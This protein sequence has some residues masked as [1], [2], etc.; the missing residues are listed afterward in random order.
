MVAFPAF[1]HDFLNKI[2]NDLE[3]VICNH[4]VS[5]LDLA[6]QGLSALFDETAEALVGAIADRLAGIKVEDE[7]PLALDCLADGV[8]IV[9]SGVDGYGRSCEIHHG[10]F[11]FS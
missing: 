4:I 7:Q 2:I 9:G 3:F 11:S 6:K 5:F 1:H 10:I 8:R